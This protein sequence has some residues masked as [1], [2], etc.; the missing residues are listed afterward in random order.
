MH[1]LRRFLGWQLTS[2]LSGAKFAQITCYV[3]AFGIFALMIRKIGRLQLTEA[4]LFF[5]VLQVLVVF[6]LIIC[7]GTLVRIHAELTKKDDS[8]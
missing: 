8:H 4:E 6:M 5:G 3:S 7:V 2:E 1:T